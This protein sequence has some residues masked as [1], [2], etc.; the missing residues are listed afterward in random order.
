M[1]TLLGWT[2]VALAAAMLSRRYIWGRSVDKETAVWPMWG[3]LALGSLMLGLGTY[4]DQLLDSLV[5]LV[6]DVIGA[7]KH[8]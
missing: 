8:G 1:Q 4:L 2:F 7:A 5:R 6:R 3:L